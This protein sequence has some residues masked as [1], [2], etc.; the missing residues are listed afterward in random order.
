MKQKKNIS[1]ENRKRVS[2]RWKKEEEKYKKHL[3]KISNSKNFKIFKSRLF[4]FLAGDG[5]ISVRQENKRINS[6]HHQIEFYPDHDSIIS[7]FIEAFTY[8]Y[9]KKP[10]IKDK[11]NF[12]SVRISLKFACLD[13]LKEA[14]FGTYTWRIP[15]NFFD[16]EK[17]KIEWLKAFF[18]CEAYVGKKV[19]QLQSVNK[20]GIVQI[21]ELLE[22]LGI[23][24]KVYEYKRKNKNWG[25]N[26]IL[27]I[28]K[29]NARK[30]YLNKIGFNHKIKL[31]K[32]KNQLA[33]V[34]ESGKR[35]RLEN[36][37]KLR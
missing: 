32:L 28:M 18:D 20:T 2:I 16:S 4:G 3:K 24:S 29:K 23:E 9:L 12:Y 30:Q 10:A 17:C 33:S 8:L 36:T 27:C 25:I 31:Q 14:N 15:L 13:I 11:G 5:H 19:I 35:G 1:E 34:P 7:P 37:K 22:N 26:Y 21:K 6:F